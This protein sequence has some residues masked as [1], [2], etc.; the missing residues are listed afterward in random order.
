LGAPK[1]LSH[2]LATHQKY[3]SNPVFIRLY[4]ILPYCIPS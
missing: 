4:S 1:N 2:P 3:Q